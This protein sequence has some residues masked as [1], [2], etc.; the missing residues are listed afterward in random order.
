MSATQ[1]ANG[2]GWLGPN[3]VAGPVKFGRLV[4]YSMNDIHTLPQRDYI[5]KGLFAPNEL[6]LL[7]GPPK[8]GKSFLAL[9]IAYR[10]ALGH[11][12]FG[13]RVRQ[14]S[15]LYV[16]AEGELG[17]AR[18]LTALETEYGRTDAFHLIAQRAD[19][20]HGNGSN[21]DLAAL[22]Q[23]AYA[24]RAGLIAIDT[25]NRAFAG[26]DENSSEDM[27]Q[28]VANMT[29]LREATGAHVLTVHHGTKS[30]DGRKP[31]GHSSLDGAMDTVVEISKSEESGDRMARIVAAK[32]DPDGSD[33]GFRLKPAVL[34]Q[35][36][37]DHQITTLLVE[38]LTTAPRLA[39]RLTTLQRG[40]R[41]AVANVIAGHGSPLPGTDGF[42]TAT[43]MGAREDDV[44][45]EC[46]A[47]HL[48]SAEQSK[49]RRQNYKQAMVALQ[50]CGW[51]AMRQGW[52][53]LP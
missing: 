2:S 24:T 45:T 31:R 28:F 43:I 39:I 51:L 14:T 15:A 35:D 44:L 47:R 6:G 32:D 34:G 40:V 26:G 27:G 41:E 21:T 50:G 5:V 23:A 42:P 12:L 52:V 22:I 33:F 37:D 16:A 7:V 18:R 48:S 38:E 13:R 11:E 53:W 19:L 1:S 17:I 36:A 4:V 20:L 25:L 29:E 9:H 3:P 30:S 46:D 10:V 8:C 49:N